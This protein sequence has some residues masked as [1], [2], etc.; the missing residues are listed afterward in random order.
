MSLDQL[1]GPATEP[2]RPISDAERV[3]SPASLDKL[4]NETAQKL[5][6]YL[7]LSEG[8]KIPQ[9]VHRSA[10]VL[11]IVDTVGDIYF[12]LEEMADRETGMSEYVRPRSDFTPA[13]H[14]IKLGHPALLPPGSSKAARIG[15]EILWDQV[16]GEENPWVINR[17]SGRYGTR[18]HQERKHL[19]AVA[20]K[21]KEFGLYF[22]VVE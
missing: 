20:T 11:W 18:P 1:Y 5:Q 19:E 17:Y 13:T 21:F 7:R 9:V 12:A 15:G 10:T 22:R 4:C 14:H 16:E 3:F 2:G 6:S 8:L